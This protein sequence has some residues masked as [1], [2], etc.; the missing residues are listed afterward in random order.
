MLGDNHAAITGT[1][2]MSGTYKGKEFSGEYRFLDL[3]EKKDGKWL[4]ICRTSP[5]SK[6]KSSGVE[7]LRGIG[8][9]PMV[10][11]LEAHATMFIP[12]TRASVPGIP[13]STRPFRAAINRGS[14]RGPAL[15]RRKNV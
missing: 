9:L 14:L 4:A 5:K 11:G 12:I 10:H 15:S 2:K 13:H 6:R 1:A 3:F 8:I 7:F